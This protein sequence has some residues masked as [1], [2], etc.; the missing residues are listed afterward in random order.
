VLDIAINGTIASHLSGRDELYEVVIRKISERPYLGYGVYG[1]WPWIGWSA[2]NMA[3]EMMAHY[4]VILGSILLLWLIVISLKS[5]IKTPN[6]I[7]KEMILIWMCYVYVRG[8]FGGSYLQFG[9][10]FMIGFCLREIRRI[11]NDYYCK[12]S[13]S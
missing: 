8:I 11:Q 10:F 2:H 6:S 4:G 5:Y 1:E 9:V 7:S 13:K 3:L 12:D